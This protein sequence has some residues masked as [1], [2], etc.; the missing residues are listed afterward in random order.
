MDPIFDKLMKSMSG[1]ALSRVKFVE[2][3]EPQPVE[4]L[5]EE[6]ADTLIG[7]LYGA[8]DAEQE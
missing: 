8:D 1:D 4:T 5:S 7:L 2:P 6:Q 3:V